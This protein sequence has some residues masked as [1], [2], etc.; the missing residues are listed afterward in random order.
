M[1]SLGLL[2]SEVL[3]LVERR[4]SKAQRSRLRA[5]SQ[6]RNSPVLWM[7]RLTPRPFCA[8]F[9]EDCYT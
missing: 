7:V 9:L 1:R 2:T 8:S 4:F 5:N 3:S 6:E